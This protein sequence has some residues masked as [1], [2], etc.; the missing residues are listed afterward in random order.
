MVL[1]GGRNIDLVLACLKD[2]SV[3][4][5][6][7]ACWFGRVFCDRMVVRSRVLRPHGGSVVHSATVW[8]FGRAFRDR[9]VVRSR[10]SR[11]HFHV[12]VTSTNGKKLVVNAHAFTTSLELSLIFQRHQ[13]QRC[14]SFF[15]SRRLK[16]VG[17][18]I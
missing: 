11:R 1:L 12:V 16:F 5:T 15:D 10:A 17:G 4:S 18:F 14:R 7:T 8:W 9:M 6:A 2:L 13:N 3:Q